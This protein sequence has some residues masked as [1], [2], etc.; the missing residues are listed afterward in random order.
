MPYA[1][2]VIW[3][4]RCS[5]M[6][7][8]HYAYT[9]RLVFH[10]LSLL[11]RLPYAV[12][13]NSI[14][15]KDYHIKKGYNP[16]KWVIIPNGFD[17]KRFKPDSSARARFRSN[18]CI[19]ETDF[20]IGMVAR[21]DPMK[22]H[23]IF[24]SAAEKL[25]QVFPDVLFILAGEGLDDHNNE[26]QKMI[27]N[28]GL[29]KKILLLGKRNDIHKVLPAFDLST[30]TSI[31]EGFPNVLG[32]SMACGVPCVSTDVGDAADIIVDTGL[33]V[34]HRNPDALAKA[35]MKIVSLSPEQRSKMGLRARKRIEDNYLLSKVVQEYEG[36]YMD[37]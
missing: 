16:R 10:L 27:I 37:C 22:G 35:W 28:K 15:G 18:K 5:N 25:I 36:F 7:L 11:S 19:G 24:L 12:V 13:A 3:N 4:I 9:T 21:Y 23:T 20:V 33:V 8:K 34:P 30:L 2:R 29:E 17:I 1:P 31:G 26:L 14:A 32:E 6:E